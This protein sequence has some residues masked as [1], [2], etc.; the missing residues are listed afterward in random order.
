MSSELYSV[1]WLKG[2]LKQL[3][4]LE[5]PVQNT[6][7][8]KTRQL[9]NNGLLPDTKKM[10]DHEN[11]FRIRIGQYR[12]VYYLERKEKQCF[13]SEI[14]HRK[15]IYRFIKTKFFPNLR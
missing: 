11:L 9:A 8:K 1:I 14:A 12:V 15:D 13:I 4:K 7:V 10:K 3:S 5:K 6:I 2:A